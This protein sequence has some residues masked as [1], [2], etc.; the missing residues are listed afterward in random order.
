MFKL[1]DNPKILNYISEATMKKTYL[2]I[3][4]KSFYASVECVERGLNPLTTNLVVADNARTE[5]TIC[6][7]VTPSMKEY[8]IPGR[9]RLFEVV[10]IASEINR[11]RQSKAPGRK[12]SK[13]SYLST[14]LKANPALAFDYIVATPQMALYMD[15]STRI[16]NIYLKYIAPEDILVYSIDEVFMDITAYLGIYSQ[17]PQ[18]LA[19]SIIRDVLNSTGITATAGIG[20]NMYLAKI[21]MDIKAK[22]MPADKDGVRIAFLDE[23]SYRRELWSHKP[24]TDFWRIG[25]GYAGKLEKNH[26][27]TM[28][29]VARASTSVYGRKLL[30]KLFGINAKLL[31]DH[32]WGYEPCTL[33]EAMSYTPENTSISMGQVLHCAY[34]FDG[35]R[36][37]VREMTELLVLDLVEKHLV[38]N[39]IVLTVGYDIENLKDSKISEK[40]TGEV[41]ADYLGRLV[42][43]HA[44]GTANIDRFTS[45]TM[46]ISRAVMSLYDKITDPGLLVRRIN[47]TACHLADEADGKSKNAF[48]QTDMFTD[49]E[50]EDMHKNREDK[51]LEKERR[52]QKAT[53]EIRN[54]FG[55]NAILKAMNLQ[56]GA[57]T[58]ERNRQIGGHK[59]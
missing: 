48:E 59:A 49:Y 44:H 36:L 4:L 7:A 19:V 34:D 20:T 40:Y 16:Y 14:E 57:T 28:G 55:K 35:A 31:I 54:R 24:L 2:C 56:E 53:V 8:G 6:L 47:L 50:A 39:Q 22:K 30:K 37:I 17:S 23:M 58:P 21:A 13:K 26:M 38:T 32:A 46:L 51:M 12:L 1:P 3:D 11:H 41:R 9:A 18:E 10:Q 52:L 25:H 45:S 15:Y 43:K 42:P 5:K 29:D 27:Y 33:R